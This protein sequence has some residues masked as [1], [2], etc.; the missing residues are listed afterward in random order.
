MLTLTPT[1]IGNLDDIT[2]RAIKTIQDASL[3]LCEDTRVSKRLLYLLSERLNID[4]GEKEY[5]S[6]NEHNAKER[7]ELIGDRL[8]S[9][10]CIYM[11]DAGMPAISD[12]GQKLV[13]YCQLNNI[14]YDV[15]PGANAVTVAYAA[16]G[17]ESGKFLFFAFLP[18]KGRDRESALNR[19]LSSIYDVVLYE[20]PHRLKKLLD[21]ICQR[22]SDRELF[23][24]KEISK[25]YQRYYRGKA[26][27]VR[28]D[29]LK[30]GEIRGEWVVVIEAREQKQSQIDI[31]DILSADIPPKPKAKL[32]SKIT[33]ESVKLWY[34]RINSSAI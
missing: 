29:I 26:S 8:K 12:P 23:C 33:G 10:N 17:F 3:L 28:E 24:A 13:R 21:D 20:S 16:S 4:F 22:D 31:E 1:P 18:H 25:K 32:L 6:F 5:L 30:D 34:D 11:S 7:L 14:D 2:N 19:V 27:K 15:L 9:E